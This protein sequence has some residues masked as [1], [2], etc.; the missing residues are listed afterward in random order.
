V[1]IFLY[2]PIEYSMIIPL[3]D[4]FMVN[5]T[6]LTEKLGKRGWKISVNRDFVRGEN[7]QRWNFKC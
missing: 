5:I 3:M 2:F 6:P 4:I 1:D 7:H